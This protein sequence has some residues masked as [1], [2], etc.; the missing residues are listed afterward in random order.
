MLS[1][2]L[3]DRHGRRRS[4]FRSEDKPEPTGDSEIDQRAAKHLVGLVL[5]WERT[6]VKHCSPSIVRDSVVTLTQTN[7]EPLNDILTEGASSFRDLITSRPA[8]HSS[9]S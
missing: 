5:L 6:D 1:K 9:G 8:R 2:E 7:K 3:C 4:G